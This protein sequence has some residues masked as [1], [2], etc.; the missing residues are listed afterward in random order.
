M[1]LHDVKSK[2][3]SLYNY[4]FA[5]DTSTS[6]LANHLQF[7]NKMLYITRFQILIPFIHLSSADTA[8]GS[9]TPDDEFLFEVFASDPLIDFLIDA[10]DNP[11]SAPI[12]RAA[13]PMD[14]FDD[15][16][17]SKDFPELA[18]VPVCGNLESLS[19]AADCSHLSCSDL[20]APKYCDEKGSK[21]LFPKCEC[22]KNYFGQDLYRNKKGECV[23]KAICYDEA[24]I[25]VF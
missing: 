7:N 20:W 8:E 23:E 18:E 4:L 9:L 12:A 2:C 15:D 10:V 24:P 19:Y 17:F 14:L 16:E 6:S 5:V 21:A 25:S 22:R 1:K 13:V 3:I 11:D